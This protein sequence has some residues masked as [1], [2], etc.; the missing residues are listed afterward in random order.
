MKLTTTFPLEH[1][2]IALRSTP[3]WRAAGR[4]PPQPCDL[5]ASALPGEA[6]VLWMLAHSTR[7]E[8]GALIATLAAA[9]VYYAVHRRIKSRTAR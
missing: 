1:C 6:T 2:E 5:A 3:T 9:T 4:N 7:R 8:A